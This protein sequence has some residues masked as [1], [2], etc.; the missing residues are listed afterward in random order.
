LK[1]KGANEVVLNVRKL[2]S[3]R[4]AAG[5]ERT[6]YWDIGLRGFGVRVAASGRK[7]FTVRYLLHSKRYRRDLGVYRVTTGYAAARTEAERIIS[8]SRNE[9]DPFISSALLKKA[10]VSTFE[11][12]C[13]RYLEDPAPGRKGRVLSEVTRT[14]MSRIIAKELI[15]AWGP[16]DPNAIQPEEIEAW[17][18][19]V[20][21]GAGRKKA[22]PYLANRSFDYMA[23]I[24]SWAIRRRLMRYTPFVGLEKPFA[25]QKRT[26]T[27][28]NDEL[29]RLFEALK[30]A[31][32]QI[33]GLWL[34]LFY[35]GNRLRETL[36]IE[37]SWIDREKKYVILPGAV[38]KNKRDHLVPL[39]PEALKLLD[40]LKPLAVGSPHVF[41][42]PTGDPMNWVQ[43]ACARV[44]KNAGIADGRHHDTRRVLQTNMAEMGVPPHVADMILNHA[45]KDAP[46]SRQ[47]Y[48][49]HHYIPEKRRALTQWT[50]R[51]RRVIGY[52]PNEIMKV[53]RTG[54]QGKGAARRLA[55]PETYRQ[56]KARLAAE[57]RDLAAE[58]RQLRATKQTGSV[59]AGTPTPA[60]PR[61]VPVAAARQS[62]KP[63]ASA[64]PVTSEV[65]T[66]QA[67]D[68]LNVSRPFV[69]G[70][71]DQRQIPFHKVGTHRRI[72]VEDL[73]AYKRRRDASRH[74]VIA[75]LAAEAQD[76]GIYEE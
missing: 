58:R 48:D 76:M 33:A 72:Q 6:E 68:L 49:T 32:K 63:G 3:L 67:A 28:G 40:L 10:D 43:K 41:P 56:R 27:F 44:M 15:P 47:H 62:A 66:Q 75:G 16:R 55:T 17:V 38:T 64:I 29:R 13:S 2:E 74:A 8:E 46:K 37:W 65:T 1:Q 19:G 70:L 21:S 54:F 4:P 24:Y 69:I 35:T 11:G 60:A 7:T 52:N 59:K 42:G 53:K 30:K 5:E 36:K 12:L 50:G 25:E 51:L 57:G 9:R 26:K 73:L 61:A 45:I 18:R 23:M 71:L 20:A 34:M 39:V 22:T 14:G 31:P